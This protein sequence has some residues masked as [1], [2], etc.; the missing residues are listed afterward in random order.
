MYNN[1]TDLIWMMLLEASDGFRWLY[2][3]IS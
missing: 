2:V 1:L 3:E